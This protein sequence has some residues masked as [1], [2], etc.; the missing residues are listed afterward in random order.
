MNLPAIGIEFLTHFKGIIHGAD[1]KVKL[2][3]VFLHNFHL[4]CSNIFSWKES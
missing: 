4:F 1:Q 3:C 2:V